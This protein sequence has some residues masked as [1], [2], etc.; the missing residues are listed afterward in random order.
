MAETLGKRGLTSRKSSI[1]QLNSPLQLPSP[2]QTAIIDEGS[3]E[4]HSSVNSSQREGQEGE[5]DR[6]EDE[7]EEYGLEEEDD[8]E[9]NENEMAIMRKKLEKKQA[10]AQEEEKICGPK[11]MHK[12]NRFLKEI[13]NQVGLGGG[14]YYDPDEKQKKLCATGNTSVFEIEKHKNCN[15]DE[16]QKLVKTYGDEIKQ[17]MAFYE[18]CKLA[19]DAKYLDPSINNVKVQFYQECDKAR[20]LAKP[21]LSKLLDGQLIIRDTKLNTG[22]AKGLQLNFMNHNNMV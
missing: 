21:I 17:Q 13:N 2:P 1:K 4:D 14:K 15:E 22:H 20:N 10:Q 18:F 6:N 3:Q 19:K 11:L 16:P 9:A 5:E 8:E 12:V 7:A